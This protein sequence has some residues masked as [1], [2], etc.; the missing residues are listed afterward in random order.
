MPP[1]TIPKRAASLSPWASRERRAQVQGAFLCT[2]RPPL[3][4]LLVDDVVTTGSTLAAAARTLRRAGCAR[5]GAVALARVA[6]TVE[7]TRVG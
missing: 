4:V 1:W 2:G 3:Q 5:V 6:V 7:G